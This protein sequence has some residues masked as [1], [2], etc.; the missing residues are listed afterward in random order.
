MNTIKPGFATTEFLGVV[1]SLV[2]SAA[3]LFKLIPAEQA[4]VYQD[5]L[6]QFLN[7]CTQIASLVV[8]AYIAIK[9][10]VAY[11]E[12]RLKLKQQ[13]LAQQQIAPLTPQP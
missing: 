12:G 10:L 8:A 11:I 9:P 4:L 13:H 6:M 3:V 7:I 1:V 5:S 2:I